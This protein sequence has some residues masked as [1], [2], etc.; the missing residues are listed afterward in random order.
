MNTDEL[1]LI[2]HFA[3]DVETWETYRTMILEH[4][5]LCKDFDHLFNEDLREVGL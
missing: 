3:K 2:I 1:A 4:A 5:H